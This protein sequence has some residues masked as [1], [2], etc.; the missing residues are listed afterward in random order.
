M[1]M[2]SSSLSVAALMF[3]ATVSAI[4]IVKLVRVRL[5]FRSLVSQTKCD[6]AL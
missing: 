2:P 4:F 6:M 3:I 1:G 5:F